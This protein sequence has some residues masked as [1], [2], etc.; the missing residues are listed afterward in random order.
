MFQSVSKNTSKQEGK[1]LRTWGVEE[2]N[3]SAGFGYGIGPKNET[4][5]KWSETQETSKQIKN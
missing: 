3:T 2:S 1:S 4:A 5:H